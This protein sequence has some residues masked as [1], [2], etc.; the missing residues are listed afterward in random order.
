MPDLRVSKSALNAKGPNPTFTV[1]E[2][3]FAKVD[4]ADS[5]AADSKARA[6]F[7]ASLTPGQR[8][9]YAAFTCEREVGS[10]GLDSYLRYSWGDY[11]PEALA[12]LQAVGAKGFVTPLAKAIALFPKG[13]PSR[14]SDERFEQLDA[15]LEKKPGVL[16]ALDDAFLNG[17]D[18][19]ESLGKAMIAYIKAHPA[20]FFHD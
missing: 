20:D 8:I 1:L 14:D 7:I 4:A 19:E 6:K 9:V 12:G 3:V 15:I 11:A 5:D 17:Y 10:G 18:E 16:G 13:V 2:A